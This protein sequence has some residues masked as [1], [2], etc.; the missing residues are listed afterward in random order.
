[1]MD[2]PELVTQKF[3]KIIDNIERAKR[4]MQKGNLRGAAGDVHFL[5][6]NAY[7][8]MYLLEAEIHEND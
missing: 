6:D 3:D 7:E 5:I 2:Q 1:M 8:A 4:N